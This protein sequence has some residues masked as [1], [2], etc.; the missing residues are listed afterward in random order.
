MPIERS[1]RAAW[2]RTA[3]V[4]LLPWVLLLA[5][6][7]SDTVNDPETPRWSLYALPKGADVFDA[8]VALALY[9]AGRVEPQITHGVGR[10]FS[11]EDLW[12]MAELPRPPYPGAL[13]FLSVEPPLLQWV[14]LYRVDRAGRPVKVGS[15]GLAVPVAQ[16]VGTAGKSHFVLIDE[17]NWTSTVM[18]RIRVE[19]GVVAV[20]SVRLES[21]NERDAVLRRDGLLVGVLTTAAVLMLI[22]VLAMAATTRE[23]ALS[24]WVMLAVFGVFYLLVWNGML[25]QWMP[26]MTVRAQLWLNAMA[27]AAMVTT[28]GFFARDFF[29]LG[30][31]HRL[32][33]G[34]LTTLAWAPLPAAI[35]VWLL[36]L[37][38]GFGVNVIL[39]LMALCNAPLLLIQLYRGQPNAKRY[40]LIGLALIYSIS[41][42]FA[43][44]TGLVP[45]SGASL[46]VWQWV[47]LAGYLALLGDLTWRTVRDRQAS[48][49][50][51]EQLHGLL[52]EEAEQLE[53]RVQ[54]RTVALRA[55]NAELMEAEAHQRE[56][57]SLASYEFRTP[58]AKIRSTL[59]ALHDLHE[60]VP[61]DV[62]ERLDNLRTASDRLIFLA[63]KLITHDRWREL[64]VKPQTK[65]LW[66]RAWMLEL[67]RDYEA[68]PP[69]SVTLPH[70]DAEIVADPVLLRIAL[71]NLIDNALAHGSKGAGAVQVGLKL[72]SNTVEFSVADDG[73][74]VPDDHKSK[75]FERFVSGRSSGQGHGLG[76]S[77]VAS[78]VRLHGGQVGVDDAQPHGARFWMALPRARDTQR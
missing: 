20:A 55:A 64:S 65:P 21:A 41:Y 7:W 12:L 49:R 16:R 77:I 26:P 76:L 28:T 47:L 5:V 38:P 52:V 31:V 29:A 73:P 22:A 13:R 48:E 74:G 3:L 33:S 71:Q 43:A 15:T 35:L 45:V 75:V 72:L 44:V 10:G 59:D 62:Q 40:G 50:E 34:I 58:A 27:A 66:V 19:P 9:R 51:R 39:I 32:A 24:S 53:Q 46:Y 60:P 67:M 57:L 4:L 25:A 61:Q 37:Q 6:A 56:L 30:Q 1:T 23:R 17:P 11:D 54:E 14:D 78:V 63:N 18:L 36:G 8:Q 70:A 42:Y 69:V 2:L 68:G